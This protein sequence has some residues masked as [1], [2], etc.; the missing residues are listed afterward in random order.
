MLPGRFMGPR[1]LAHQQ[2]VP[3][4]APSKVFIGDE[5]NGLE[6]FAGSTGRA[7]WETWIG[8]MQKPHAFLKQL[9]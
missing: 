4:T 5:I 1:I 7:R 2:T 9:C 3:G 8:S 6:G